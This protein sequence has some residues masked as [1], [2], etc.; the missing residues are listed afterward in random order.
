MSRFFQTIQ[1]YRDDTKGM[2]TPAALADV[3]GDGI[4]D[5][6]IASFNSH[7]LAFDGRSFTQIWNNS[8]FGGSESYASVSV[9]YYD[10]DNVP[11]FMV[12]YQFGE[13][14]PVYQYEEVCTYIHCLDGF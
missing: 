9:G 1:I 4:E 6:V 5:I 3:T 8:D 11:D 7:V 2:M 14:Y 10:D 13:G 12:K